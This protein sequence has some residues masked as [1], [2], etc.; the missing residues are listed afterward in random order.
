MRFRVTKK[1]GL[2]PPTTLESGFSRIGSWEAFGEKTGGELPLSTESSK[3][4]PLLQTEDSDI[5]RTD[6]ITKQNDDDRSYSNE[7]GP[8][9]GSE[10]LRS[11]SI[12]DAPTTILLA[13]I[14]QTSKTSTIT[15]YEPKADDG[16]GG[17]GPAPLKLRRLVLGNIEGVK[18]VIARHTDKIGVR[19]SGEVCVRSRSNSGDMEKP[20]V[21]KKLKKKKVF[22]VGSTGNNI[23]TA[24]SFKGGASN[25][26]VK[27][28][29]DCGTWNS[30]VREEKKGK[31][32]FLEKA[33][34]ESCN[35]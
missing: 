23:C 4:R 26:I 22:G 5:R 34:E 12:N 9:P 15:N 27:D 31:K 32:R 13:N 20:K 1:T 11:E 18:E 28:E 2:T 10:I 24:N 25:A 29:K 17:G 3:L 7:D 21:K 35:K 14:I 19:V 30:V 8:Y 33:N 16:E 6:S